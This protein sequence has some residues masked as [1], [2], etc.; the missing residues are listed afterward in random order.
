[1]EKSFFFFFYIK[2][3]T[4]TYLKSSNI[5]PKEGSIHLQ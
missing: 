2:K 5:L 4:P 3:K 1:M